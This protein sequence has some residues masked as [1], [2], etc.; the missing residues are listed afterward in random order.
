MADF[1][2]AHVHQVE[3]ADMVA[4]ERA[5]D[6]DESERMARDWARIN[7]LVPLRVRRSTDNSN[8]GDLGNGEDACAEKGQEEN[9]EE[10]S[11]YGTVEEILTA[12]LEDV[13][14]VWERLVDK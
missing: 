14:K 12:P 13:R 6:G 9:E 1:L 3:R 8:G 11:P 7:V 4:I 2:R 10:E 5:L